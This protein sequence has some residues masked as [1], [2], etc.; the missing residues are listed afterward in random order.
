MKFS[1][2]NLSKLSKKTFGKQDRLVKGENTT[3]STQKSNNDI[4]VIEKGIPEPLRNISYNDQLRIIETLKQLNPGESFPIKKELMY[5][6]RKMTN[7]YFPEYKVWIRPIG[8]SYR[9]FRRA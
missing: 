3:E 5:P 6:V 4:F 8:D 9:V 7:M 2:L 1:K